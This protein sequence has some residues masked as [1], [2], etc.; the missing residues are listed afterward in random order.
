MTMRRLRS[1]MYNKRKKSFPEIP[2]SLQGLTQILLQPQFRH[3]SSTIDETD[4]LYAGSVTAHDGS[5]HVLFMSKRMLG[6]MAEVKILQADGTFRARPAV[7]PST[8]CFVIATP[9][10]DAV[11]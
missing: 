1:A 8:Q 7:P 6:H 3:I 9:W 10:R 4:N 11:R 5:H 2:Q